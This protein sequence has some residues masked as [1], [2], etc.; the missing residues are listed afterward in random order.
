MRL[1][2]TPQQQEKREQFA[3]LSQTVQSQK[4]KKLEQRLQ[5][6]PSPTLEENA[7]GAFL[8]MYEPHLVPIVLALLSK[9]QIV[10]PTS[11][12]HEEFPECQMLYGSFTFDDRI[13]HALGKLGVIVQKSTNKKSIKF[14][15][16]E[17]RLNVILE[18]YERIV[19]LFPAINRDIQISQSPAAKKFRRTYTPQDT[20]L[21]QTRLLEI[22]M[23]NIHEQMAKEIHDRLAQNKTPSQLES[24]LGTFIEMIEPQV[25][26]AVIDLYKKGYT[27]DAYGFLGRSDIQT[28]EGDFV[29]DEA[30][31]KKLQEEDVTVLTNHVGYTSI[32]FQ[33]KRADYEYVYKKWM[34]IAGMIPSLKKAL[35]P[36]MTGKAREFRKKYSA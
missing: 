2:L 12:F 22:L 14:Y 18:T 21:K 6:N 16:E 8:E 33:P 36:C 28:M 13:I 26:D 34:T 32:Q 9:G 15:P 7:L 24:N 11:G 29:L 3:F 23:F 17:A 20:Q 1:P 10:E 31:Q 25:R 5:T 4:S 27:A 35:L 19:D 30:T